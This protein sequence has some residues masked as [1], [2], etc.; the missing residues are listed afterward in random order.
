MAGGEAHLLDVP[1][2]EES[3]YI[4]CTTCSKGSMGNYMATIVNHLSLYDVDHMI[5]WSTCSMP[6]MRNWEDIYYELPSWEVIHLIWMI[7]WW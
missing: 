6:L 5:D 2:G 3:P 4:F 7:A 1:L